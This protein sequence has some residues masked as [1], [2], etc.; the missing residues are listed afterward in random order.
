MTCLS[1]YSRLI[2][3]G[4]GYKLWSSSLRSLLHSPFSSLL[5]PNISVRIRFS[6]T[7]SLRFSLNVR[8][9][10]SQSCSTPG[11]N[12]ILYI[13]YISVFPG[14]F[15]CEHRKHNPWNRKQLLTLRAK[16]PFRHLHLE[17]KEVPRNCLCSVLLRYNVPWLQARKLDVNM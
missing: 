4:W 15:S 9:H 13:S 10:G 17:I 3:P 2:H 14:C 16:V 6:N 5:G 12:I 8:D 11:N 7:I 1:Q